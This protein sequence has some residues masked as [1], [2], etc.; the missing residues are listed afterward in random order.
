[1]TDLFAHATIQKTYTL[2]SFSATKCAPTR[3]TNL[4]SQFGFYAL[5]GR[6]ANPQLDL[7]KVTLSVRAIATAV[8]TRIKLGTTDHVRVRVW[9]PILRAL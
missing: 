1:M 3:L 2:Y 8:R 9:R 6:A 5:M 7:L 4:E